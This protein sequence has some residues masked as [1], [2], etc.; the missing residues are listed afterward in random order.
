MRDGSYVGDLSL[1]QLAGFVDT[2][3]TK[4]ERTS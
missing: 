1:G 2:Q 4:E 3:L